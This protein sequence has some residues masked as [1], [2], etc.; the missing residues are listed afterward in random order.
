LPYLPNARQVVV[1]N[2]GH[3]NFSPCL[4][5]LRVAFLDDPRP[6]TLDASCA[7]GQKRPP[8]V[9]DLAAWLAKLLHG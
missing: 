8:F 5:R 4:N 7:A 1:P 9:I 2:G 6:R 3:S